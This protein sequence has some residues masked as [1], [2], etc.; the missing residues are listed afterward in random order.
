MNKILA[1]SIT[2]LLVGLQKMSAQ[3]YLDYYETINKAE[4]ANLDKEFK[5]SDSLYQVAFGLIEKPFKE[6][7][8]LASINSDKLNDNK[9]TLEYLKKGINNGL[10]LKRIKNSLT[11]FKKSKEW[12]EVKTEYNSLRENH[13]KTLNLTLREEIKNMLTKD[14]ASR[15]P[16]FGSAKKSKKI[17]NNNYKRL[18]EIIDEN[19]G[20]WPGFSTIGET[21]PKGKYNV[22]GNIALMILH[23]DKEQI[24]KLKPYMLQA[25]MDG[26][27]YPYHFA[28]AIDYK[29]ISNC[30]PF[31]TYLSGGFISPICDC[32]KA[33]LERKKFGFESIEDY[34]RKRK[35][36]YKCKK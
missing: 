20:K 26:E 31:G 9:K 5:K 4:I 11:E 25:V 10:T 13:L 32:E 14:Q 29:S 34:Y 23:F 3:N 16:I 12:K 24:E 27:M 15:H 19:G 30:Q 7:F 36:E 18:L 2:I 17:D 21:L 28:R 22:T 1:F 6:D 33:N 35:S 8:L